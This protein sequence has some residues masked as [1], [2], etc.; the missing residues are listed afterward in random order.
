MLDTLQTAVALA[1]FIAAA[2]IL[3]YADS[4]HAAR[5]YAAMVYSR[6]DLTSRHWFLAGWQDA[7]QHCHD[8]RPCDW[9]EDL[10]HDEMVA[11]CAYNSGKVASRAYP[12]LAK[13]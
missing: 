4:E 2:L 11:L 5:Q 1:C 9:R 7:A 13:R 8:N 12:R 10:T 6:G 3:W